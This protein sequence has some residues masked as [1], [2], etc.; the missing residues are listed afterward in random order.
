MF[1]SL[2][3]PQES[4]PADESLLA[5][6]GRLWLAGYPVHW[7]ALHEGRRRVPLPTY[8]F[9][10]Q[11]FWIE[12]RVQESGIIPP[13]SKVREPVERWFH[14]PSW[15]R[16]EP[17]APDRREAGGGSLWVLLGDE[18][19]LGDRLACRLELAGHRVVRVRAGRELARL[20]P[21]AYA[22]DPAD[23]EAYRVLCG[24]LG[25][26]AGRRHFIHLW[27]LEPEAD[28]TFAS[29][30]TRGFLSLIFLARAVAASGSGPFEISVVTSGVQDVT[31]DEELRPARATLAGP[32]KVIPQE[33]PHLSCRAIDLIVPQPGSPAE[34]RALDL[35]LNELLSGSPEPVVAYRGSSRWLQVFEPASWSL[36]GEGLT[37]RRHGVYVILGGL[38][39]I[40]RQLAGYLARTRQARLVLTRRSAFPARGDWESW[41][42]RHGE[43][44]AV[45][46]VLLQL[47]ELEAAG[48]EVWTASLDA[49]D[50]PALRALLAETEARWGGLHGVIHAAGVVG[51]SGLQPIEE[52]DA[53]TVDLHFRPKVRGALALDRALEGR[54]LDFCLLF[55]SLSSLLGGLGF[56]A[57]AGANAFQDALANLRGRRGR[58]L[59]RSID[60][61]AWDLSG[62]VE[63]TGITAGE[64]DAVF[65]AVF[66][67]PRV[68]QLVVSTTDLESRR[69]RW[70]DPAHAVV[71]PEREPS[72]HA[73]P[74][75]SVS[76][77][78]P[79]TE[80]ERQIAHVWRNLLGIE[81]VGIYDNFFELGGHSLLATQMAA[82]LRGVLQT[83]LP[84]RVIFDSPTIVGLSQALVAVPDEAK[85][86]APAI[87]RLPREEELPLSFGQQQLWFLNQLE[88]ENPYYNL[89]AAVYLEGLLDRVALGHSLNHIVRRHEVLRTSF[90]TN[91][92]EPVQVISPDLC[93][94]LPLIDLEGLPP[95]LQRAE[96]SRISIAEARRVFNLSRP[97]LLR[98]ALLH[99][100]RREHV[101]LLTIHHIVWD[102]WSFAIFLRE[103]AACYESCVQ[104][105][106]P[107]LPELPVQYADFA[108]WQRSW[109]K[110]DVLRRNWTTGVDVWKVRRRCSPCRRTGPARRSRP[111]GELGG[112]WS[113]PVTW[114]IPSRPSPFGRRSLYSWLSS[115]ASRYCSVTMHGATI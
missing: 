79:R 3:H 31:G 72:L 70:S 19:G 66:A 49:A 47:R 46:Q 110:G 64:A 48:A 15:K 36:E 42:A 112:F 8:P 94:D 55:S 60:W 35:L 28:E 82:Q 6:A 27:S 23:P 99:V 58:T 1:S 93:L 18:G 95:G 53:E 90:G 69:R 61:D 13:R 12:A 71:V 26:H 96:W 74:G 102:A 44:D 113:F 80:M 59:W 24:E 63:G 101:L 21:D 62:P 103:M 106:S 10:R 2:P 34:D 98:A 43:E 91:L 7:Q 84:L 111:S 108:S 68:S 81:E 88:P 65:Q 56:S 57:Y 20:G 75:L 78:P 87:A 22:I 104:G 107:K 39:R 29:A 67:I 30:Q 100:A 92:T 115:P 45:S 41:L 40:G 51:E 86:K 73:R 54:D 77:V 97:P 37:L 114:Q 14:L 109:L 85:W 16:S 38:G 5:A 32:C 83:A 76:Y 89:H 17:P 9:E 33:L 52:I 11:R 50:E 105:R 25:E 4:T